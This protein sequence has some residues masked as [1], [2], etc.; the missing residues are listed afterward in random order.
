MELARGHFALSSTTRILVDRDASEVKAIGDYLAD[1]LR[2]ATGRRLPVLE[3]AGYLPAD[4]IL[5]TTIGAD[6]DLG[7]EGYELR[8]TT[9]TVEVR[10]PNPAGLF[11]GVQTLRQLLPT[12]PCLRIVDRPQ[13]PWRGL[14]LDSGRHFMTKEFVKKYI[15]LLAMH[16][17][18]RLHWHLTEDQGWR[19]EI[20]RYPKL[21][22]VGAWRGQGSERYGGY[23][24]QE[25][26]RDIVAY[27]ESRYVM[28]VPEIEMPGHSVAALAAYPELSCTGGPFEVSTRWGVHKDVYCAGNDRTFGFLEGVLTEVLNLFPAPYIHL[29]ADEVPKERWAACA[30]CQARIKTEGLNNEHELQTYFVRR[31][32]RFVRDAGRRAICWDEILEGGAPEGVIVQAWHG[33]HKAAEALAAGHETIVSPTSHVYF[34][35]DIASY[36]LRNVYEFDPVPEGTAPEDLGRVLGSEACMWTEHAPQQAVDAKVFPRLLGLAE[37]LWSPREGRDFKDFYTRVQAHRRRLELVG[38]VAGPAF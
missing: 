19:I 18:N 3:V 10:A 16:K 35:Y 2:P 9:V 4:T 21:T 37:V 28:V 33:H 1:L 32:A 12:I 22:T 6:R 30:K 36:H 7:E 8:V 11:Y 20:K 24:T 23:Y 14:L 25:D 34:D 27:A 38:V 31:M 13:Y 5:L 17:L 29:G 15:D 26:I